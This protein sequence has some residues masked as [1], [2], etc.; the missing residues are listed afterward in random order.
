MAGKTKPHAKGSP[1]LCKAL[2][3][4]A[5]TNLDIAEDQK[6]AG[7]IEGASASIDIAAEALQDH[8]KWGCGGSKSSRMHKRIAAWRA[9]KG[10]RI[11]RIVVARAK[12]GG[13]SP[14][15]SRRAGTGS[16]V[17]P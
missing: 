1:E 8:G 15:R 12:K 11:K 17:L 6:A 13:R 16:A 9:K 2:N 3:F 7:D 10:S 4:I 14:A 5:Q